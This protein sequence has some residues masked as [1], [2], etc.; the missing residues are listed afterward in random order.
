MRVRPAEFEDI[1]RLLAIERQAETAAHWSEQ[2]Y[3]VIFT[4]ASPRRICLVVEL[5]AGESDSTKS[6]DPAVLAPP[7]AQVIG[8]AVVLCFADEWEIENVAIDPAFRRQ[9][10]AS[11]LLD[12]LLSRATSEGVESVCLEVRESNLAARNLY[13]KWGFQEVGVRPEYYRNPEEDAVLF[14]FSCTDCALKNG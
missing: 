5:T 1:P 12:D 7:S 2:N 14:R 9:G 8:F 4:E 6:D 13:L 3:N 10:A 11:T